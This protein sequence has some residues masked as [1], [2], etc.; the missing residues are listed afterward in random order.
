MKE[1]L[2]AIFRLVFAD[3]TIQLYDAMTANDIEG[4]DSLSHAN[5]ICAIEYHF[6][7]RFTSKELLAMKCVG[8]LL[9]GI[10][11]KTGLSQ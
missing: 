10:S 1:Q 2:V 3:E 11:N 8:D 7:I 4:W 5:L 9:A 6:N